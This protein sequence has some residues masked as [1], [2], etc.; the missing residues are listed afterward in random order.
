MTASELTLAIRHQIRDNTSRAELEFVLEVVGVMRKQKGKPLVWGTEDKARLAALIVRSRDGDLA[1]AE[2]LYGIF[3]RPIFNLAYRHTLNRATAEDLLQDIFLKV[4]TNLRSV[5]EVETF[6]G[7]IYRIALNTCYSHLRQKRSSGGTSVSL[8][9]L[10]GRLEDE[11]AEPVERDLRIPLE[12]A[13]Q[14]LPNRLRSVFV[15]HDI[16][17]Y[18]HEEISRILKCSVGTSKS[19]LF[20]ARLKLRNA[21]KAKA[22]V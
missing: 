10:E 6:P 12:N 11:A 18:K 19:Q 8:E 15:L 1:A 2:E 14:D 9:G 21:L 13:I 17:G 3:K 5:R 7:W 22:V 4:F 16:E 20:K